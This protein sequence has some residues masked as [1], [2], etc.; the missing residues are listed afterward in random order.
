MTDP[1]VF[2]IHHLGAQGQGVALR[3]DG[4]RIYVSGALPG[5]TVRLA[6]VEGEQGVLE[7]VLTPAPQRIAPVCPHYGVCG[8]CALQHADEKTYAAFKRDL[9]LSTLSK[10]GVAAPPDVEGPLISAP[11]SRR[12][13]TFAARKK[14]GRLLFGFNERRSDRIAAI[15]SC[16]VLAPRIVALLPFMRRYLPDIL[17]ENSKADITL[18]ILE[19][20]LDMLITGRLSGET[21]Q[22]G[23]HATQAL[24]DLCHKADLS[25]LS[26]RRDERADPELLLQRQPVQV[27]FADIAVVP[28]A[29][30]FLQATEEGERALQD[31]V[32]S[33]LTGQKVKRAADLYAG[34]GTFTF[35]LL[36]LGCRVDAFEGYVPSVTALTAAGKGQDRLRTQSRDLVKMPLRLPELKDYDAVVIDPP[37]DGASPQAKILAESAVPHIVYISCSAASFARDADYLC[38]GGYRLARLRLVD[39]FLWSHHIEIAGFFTRLPFPV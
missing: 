30:G 18:T 22:L 12:R 4:G 39:Q 37:R 31:F 15:E 5:E 34:C 2:S 16:A 24:S 14:G 1:L 28:P 29:G 13:A 25:R 32:T 7:K 8:G 19:D 23:F 11:A 3:P 36:A 9:V 33:V 21:R 35:P 26:W 20:A 38:Q 27:R 6:A 17:P 10:A